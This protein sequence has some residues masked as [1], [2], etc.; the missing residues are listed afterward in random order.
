MSTFT[1]EIREYATTLEIIAQQ[2]D[3]GYCLDVIDLLN[4]CHDLAEDLTGYKVICKIDY[5]QGRKSLH[6]TEDYQG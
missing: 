5:T 6:G 3:E 1:D 2:L 4:F